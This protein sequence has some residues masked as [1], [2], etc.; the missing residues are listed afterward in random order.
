MQNEFEDLL[1]LIDASK[2]DA[3]APLVLVPNAEIPSEAALV[4]M[5]PDALEVSDVF[6]FQ[7]NPNQNR[8]LLSLTL[9]LAPVLT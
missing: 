6:D 8:R 2:Q 1:A 4:R 3:D 9:P 5:D 7:P